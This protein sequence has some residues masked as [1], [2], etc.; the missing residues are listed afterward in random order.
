MPTF[1][2]LAALRVIKVRPAEPGVS[3]QDAGGE[4]QENFNVNFGRK[5]LHNE[6]QIARL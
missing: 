6:V 2:C 4:T 3:S 5:A 1:G